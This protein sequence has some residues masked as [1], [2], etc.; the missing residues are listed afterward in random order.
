MNHASAAGPAAAARKTERQ[1]VTF[2]SS[3]SAAGTATWAPGRPGA[4]T[5]IAPAAGP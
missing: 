1:T 4:D 5:L 2:S 3:A